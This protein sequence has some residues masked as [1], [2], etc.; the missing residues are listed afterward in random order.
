MSR[1]LLKGRIYN[2]KTGKSEKGIIQELIRVNIKQKIIAQVNIFLKINDSNKY[3]SRKY[4]NICKYEFR[5][6][7]YDRTKT[8]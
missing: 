7:I 8:L 2:T 1:N 4:L 3:F 5:Q 6:C